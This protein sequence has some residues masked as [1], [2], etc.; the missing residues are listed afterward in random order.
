MGN[1]SWVEDP[2]PTTQTL[3]ICQ[4]PTKI[5]C[6]LGTGER[7]SSKQNTADVFQ[8]YQPH[9]VIKQITQAIFKGL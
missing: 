6:E 1:G 2:N 7:A 9:A 8:A 5:F 3:F 4:I